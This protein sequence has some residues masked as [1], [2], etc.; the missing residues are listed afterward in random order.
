MRRSSGYDATT[1]ADPADI[2]AL[3]ERAV[4]HRIAVGELHPDSLLVALDPDDALDAVARAVMVA[5]I[6]LVIEG[7]PISPAAVLQ[8][9]GPLALELAASASSEL[10]HVRT[11]DLVSRAAGAASRR[12]REREA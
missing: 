2:V 5:A 9:T 8:R 6:D 7:R 10:A 3:V 11:S 12:N 4:A 1:V